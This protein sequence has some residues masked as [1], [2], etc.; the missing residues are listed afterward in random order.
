METIYNKIVNE[1][2]V[3]CIVADADFIATQEG[4]WELRATPPPPTVEE[5]ARAWR[6][7]ELL[8]TDYIVPTTD[9]PQHSDYMTYRIALRNWPSTSDFPDTRPTL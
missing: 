1:E 7:Q 4:T 8:N 6:D 2:I 5:I 9:H 3:D